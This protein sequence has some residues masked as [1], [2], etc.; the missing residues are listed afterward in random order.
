[1][2][3][4]RVGVIGTGL[5]WIR[6][7]RPLLA[8][9]RDVFQP[10]A[11][12][13][14]SAERRAAVAHDFPD[15]QVVSDY[16]SLLQIPEIETVMIF[17][18]IALN[19]PIAMAA[20]QAGKN[21]IMEK[22]I[23]RSTVEGRALVDMA[24]QHQRR[25]FVTEQMGY[26]K[27]E[28]Q[29]AEVINSGEIGDLVMWERVAHG[30]L[31]TAPPPIRYE[32]TPWRKSA[33]FPLG[34]LFDGGIHQ[35]AGLTKVF[36]VPETVFATGRKLRPEY[37]EYD[38]VAMTFQY[39]NGAVGLLSHSTYLPAVQNH[40]HVYGSRGVIAVESNRLV[41]NKPDQPQR[42]IEQ[43]VEQSYAAMWQAF[44]R[45]VRDDHP[46]YYTPERALTDVAILEMVDR[47]IKKGTPQHV[48]VPQSVREV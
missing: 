4:I 38:H 45:A 23:A 7:H 13:D 22:P 47:S 26:R 1:M 21:V 30:D 29:L 32:T 34:T 12:C 3:P 43:P 31:D 35:I 28:E 6:T 41:V 36:G 46:P 20:L 19:A 14:V 15:A 37:G 33:D 2:A 8:T 39:G 10:V 48:D 11:F 17:T 42:M 24:M 18:P 16:Q 5:I 27:A 9:L 44:A 25:L 40:F